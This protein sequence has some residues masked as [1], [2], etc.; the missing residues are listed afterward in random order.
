[1]KTKK[2]C[3]VK[4]D[5]AGGNSVLA[6]CF[7]KLLGKSSTTF[8]HGQCIE[9]KLVRIQWKFQGLPTTNH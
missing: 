8:V 4:Q 6:M 5:M 9:N 7:V 3:H 1:M 2:H